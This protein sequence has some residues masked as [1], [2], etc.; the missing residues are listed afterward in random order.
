VTNRAGLPAKAQ[1]V[2]Q[3]LA[4]IG[5]D[6]QIKEFPPGVYFQKLGNPTE[7][8]D[9][10][11]LGWLNTVPDPALF[12]NFLFDG[13]LIGQPGNVDVSYFNSPKWN[14][15]LR[16][17][18]RLKGEARYRTYAKLDIELARDEAPA[19]AFSVDNALTTP[20]GRLPTGMVTGAC[21]PD[22]SIFVTVPSSE[23]ATRTRAHGPA[24][25]RAAARRRAREVDTQGDSFF[26]AFGR[27]KEAA[28]GRECRPQGPLV[29]REHVPPERAELPHKARRALDVGEE[30]CDGPGRQLDHRSS[31]T[32]AGA[33]RKSCAARL[34]PG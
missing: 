33:K 32:E 11:Y 26:V 10:A 25:G 19:F 17:A 8:Y 6:V 12:L 23:F 20:A 28:V 13:G 31:L 29:L 24:N 16:A 1:I 14:H 2:K 18:A 15:A 22:G 4:R 34:P 27:A 21:R 3:E 7:P 5:L 30:K 9:M